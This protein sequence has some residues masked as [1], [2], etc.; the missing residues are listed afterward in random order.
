MNA[1]VIEHVRV[2]ELP[3]SWQ[4][5]FSATVFAQMKRVTVRIEE[6]VADSADSANASSMTAN[7]LFGMWRDREDMADVAGYM[8][9]LRQPRFAPDG[10]PLVD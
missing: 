6:E 7:P 1:V 10:T 9:D 4:D 3:A 2:S 5:K 8:R